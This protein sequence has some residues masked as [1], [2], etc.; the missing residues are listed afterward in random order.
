[1]TKL[2]NTDSGFLK[3]KNI[4]GIADFFLRHSVNNILLQ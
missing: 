1:M 2:M 3:L 4:L